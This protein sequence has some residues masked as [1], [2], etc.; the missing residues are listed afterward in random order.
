MT[1]QADGAMRLSARIE[2][3][4]DMK[5]LQAGRFE[6][7][8][9]PVS[10]LPFRVVNARSR[11][12]SFT[13]IGLYPVSH[14]EVSVPSN[15]P[16]GIGVDIRVALLAPSVPESVAMLED[17]NFV[18]PSRKGS[19]ANVQLT[20]DKTTLI[21]VVTSDRQTAQ[22]TVLRSAPPGAPVQLDVSSQSGNISIHALNADLKDMLRRVAVAAGRQIVLNGTAD[23][24][25]S[26]WMDDVSLHVALSTVAIAYG[27]NVD[28]SGPILQFADADARSVPSFGMSVTEI[29]PLRC[30]EA[31]AV[32]NCLPDFLLRYTSA[33]TQ[34]NT[35]TVSGPE[36]LARKV[37]EDVAVLDRPSPQVELSAQ[38]LE[39]ASS[40]DLDMALGADAGKGS[41]GAIVDVGTGDI[42]IRQLD[43]APAAFG[44]R[45]RA[46]RASGRARLVATP[47][48]TALLGKTADLFVGQRKFVKTMAFDYSNGEWTAQFV[49]V[50]V[51]AKLTVKPLMLG[52]GGVTV[53]LEPSVSTISE[54]EPVTGLPTVNTR[55]LSTTLRVKDGDTLVV[56]GLGLHQIGRSARGIPFLR[57]L[58]LIGGL[59]RL[60][61]RS[62]SSS[63]LVFLVSVHVRN[64]AE[65]PGVSAAII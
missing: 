22:P 5:A 29:I 52:D 51:G 37:R 9:K 55:K 12:S 2:D 49:G 38:V 61:G 25:V 32:R 16:E 33:D 46:L 40:E 58:P 63:E 8:A 65:R 13:D 3:F 64:A 60:P 6:D 11:V 28:D 54:L 24:T 21:V 47:S 45:L 53:H 57:D 31:A 36:Y 1:I 7:I 15:T 30:I 26:L 4:F 10:S 59:F 44:A 42:S 18:D 50:D 23:H 43:A 14:V 41:R 20:P 62:D 35:L 56:G 39:F 34:Q 17:F 19:V 27:L 48:G